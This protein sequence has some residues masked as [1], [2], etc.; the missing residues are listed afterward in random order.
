MRDPSGSL[1]AR[2][3]NF[4]SWRSASCSERPCLISSWRYGGTKSVGRAV[5]GRVDSHS[6]NCW[7]GCSSE[8]DDCAVKPN[9]SSKA[10]AVGQK[11]SLM[12]TP[13]ILPLPT[14]CWRARVPNFGWC[15]HGGG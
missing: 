15:L 4:A 9:A 12:H 6:R 2:C 13:L 8:D 5:G 10:A 11:L 1:Y 14:N 7:N 3:H